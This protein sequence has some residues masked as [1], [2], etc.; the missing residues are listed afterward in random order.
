MGIDWSNIPPGVVLLFVSNLVAS[1]VAG[2]GLYFGLT[3]SIT[4][5]RNDLKIQAL[6]G[7]QA[8]DNRGV[9]IRADMNQ[10]IGVL[11]ERLIDDVNRLDADVREVKARLQALETGSDE[12]SKTLRQRS[13]RLANQVNKL[14]LKIILLVRD[15]P[16]Q[17]E[18]TGSDLDAKES[19]SEL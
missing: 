1:T 6:Q 14:K 7:T 19:D 13:H 4:A 15:M 16:G 2:C 17:K 18:Y 8:L 10:T 12:W 11:R 3:A 5:L 9:Q